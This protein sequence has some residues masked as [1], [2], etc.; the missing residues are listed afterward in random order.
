M[1]NEKVAKTIKLN[2]SKFQGLKEG[3]VALPHQQAQQVLDEIQ[4]LA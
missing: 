3:L 4:L 1:S 2:Q